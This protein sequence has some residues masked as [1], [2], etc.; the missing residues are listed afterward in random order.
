[1]K[2]NLCFIV[3]MIGMMLISG[4]GGNP[5]SATANE[6]N[7]VSDE[8]GKNNAD[9][10][11]MSS[12]TSIDMLEE[13]VYNDVDATVKQLEEKQEKLASE[14]NTYELYIENLE[15]IKAYYDESI[16]ETNQLG[17]RLREYSL[18]YARFILNNDADYNDK[19]DDLQGIYRYIYDDAGKDM[20][21]IYDDTLKDM[22]DLYYDGIL[23]DAYETVPYEDWYDVRSDEYDLWYD[24]RSVVYDIWY[25]ARSDIYDFYS[26]IRSE[27]YDH[28]EKRIE[29]IIDKFEEDITDLK[30]KQ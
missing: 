2:K 14:I 13:H 18:Q 3:L 1:M 25:D 23:K 11:D 7:E 30:N 21:D 8:L 12:I 4:C 28:D 10:L 27:V 9:T 15:K 29:K 20:Y 6:K 5:D 16:K 24:S 19:Y 17:I 22:Y 26:D